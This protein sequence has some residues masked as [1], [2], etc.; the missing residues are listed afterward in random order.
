MKNLPLALFAALILLGWT[1]LA[2]GVIAVF[3]ADPTASSRKHDH[4]VPAHGFEIES[5]PLLSDAPCPTK[6]E[7]L[8]GSVPCEA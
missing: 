5:T 1:A 3:A 6:P 4:V 8:D 2:A 7:A